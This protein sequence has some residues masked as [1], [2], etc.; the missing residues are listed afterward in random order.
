MLHNEG[1]DDAQL[2]VVQLPGAARRRLHAGQGRQ[3]R[4]AA[5]IS[6]VRSSSA[7]VVS[8]QDLNRQWIYYQQQTVSAEGYAGQAFNT[9]VPHTVRTTETKTCT[10]CHVSAAGDNN[11]VMSQ[12]LLLGTN[13]VN[14]MGRFVFVATGKGGVE[15]VAVT[16]MDEPQAVIGSDLHQLAYPERVRRAREARPRAARPSIHHGSSNALG[17]QVRGEYL[18][19][20][21]GEGGFKVFDIAQINQK[22][23]SEKIVSAPVSPLG[24]NTNVKTRYAT[25]VAAPSHAGGRS[26]C[27]CGCRRTRSSRF[28]RSTAT[29]TSPIARKGWCCRRRRRCS[30]ATRRT[31]S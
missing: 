9:H 5:R 15:A 17:V 8:S 27:G 18:Y 19:I 2:D 12:L 14:F 29:S 3:R 25:A 22:G 30:T 10:D 21:D 31:T 16:E 13:F 28:T 11:A 24:Q 4:S 1:T 7:V 26:R 20:A 6:P 23:F